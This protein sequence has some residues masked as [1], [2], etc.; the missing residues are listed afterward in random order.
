ME[1]RGFIRTLGL[2]GGTALA[3][4]VSPLGGTSVLAP[5]FS[6]GSGPS[7]VVGAKI[8]VLVPQS[9]M[10][11]G[12]KNKLFAGL[13]IGVEAYQARGGDARIQWVVNETTVA[14]GDMVAGAK[15][16]IK[17]DRVD[18]VLS[19]ASN[20]VVQRLI[21]TVED[22]GIPLL[23]L[24]AG[25]NLVRSDERSAHVFYNT[26]GYW[27]ACYATGQRLVRQ[28]GPKIFI[29]AST[30]ETG[31]DALAA[32]R[33]GV[34][35]AGGEEG[36][37]AIVDAHTSMDVLVKILGQVEDLAPNAIFLMQSGPDAD[38]VLGRGGLFGLLDQAPTAGSPFL[39][40][41]TLGGDASK[42]AKG[43]QTCS[44][45]ANGLPSE[46]NQDFVKAYKE[47]TGTGS[48]A[49][50]LLGYDSANLLIS[51]LGA[52]GSRRSEL[53][54][55]FENATWTSP[56]GELSMNET[57]H[58]ANLPLYFRTTRAEAS[59]MKSE[60]LGA[61]VPVNECSPEVQCLM[62][63]PRVGWTNAYLSV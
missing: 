11:P 43:I 8:G 24:G 40:E 22:A 9:T 55:A 48:D 39:L 63:G 14:P 1:R 10:F 51:V 36:G 31:H 27:Q 38:A 29:L 60:S 56:R 41:G 30:Y 15:A 7:P 12:L 19:F 18:L 32:F 23:A 21:P 44:S 45:W 47:R 61:V 62:K 37:L 20:S 35:R 2:L 54:Q 46:E 58:T 28:H 3:T 5:R 34:T 26:L 17:N 49:I 13:K 52:A 50:G 25:E 42:H 53:R 33:L 59:G 4:H 16:M 57:T 6:T